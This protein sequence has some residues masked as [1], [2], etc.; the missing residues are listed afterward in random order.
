M[1]SLQQTVQ[2]N[3]V[4]IQY[5]SIHSTK[6]LLRKDSKT[7]LSF[8]LDMPNK[9]LIQHPLILGLTPSIKIHFINTTAIFRDRNTNCVIK[10]LMMSSVFPL[11]I[12]NII[13]KE[14]TQNSL[15]HPN[16][17]FLPKEIKFQA[18]GK[19]AYRII[20]PNYTHSQIRA[21]LQG[22]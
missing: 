9:C 8:I 12:T 17:P 21:L 5:R 15:T 1:Q 18:K 6:K 10:L 13:S 22:A 3:P 7:C 20:T 16:H 4:Q 19:K 11:Q 14:Y 2:A